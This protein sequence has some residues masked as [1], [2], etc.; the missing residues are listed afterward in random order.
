MHTQHAHTHTHTHT[1]VFSLRHKRG[2]LRVVPRWWYTDSTLVLTNQT[3]SMYELTASLALWQ[4]TDQE[5][6]IY[7]S[8]DLDREQ[9]GSWLDLYPWL[10]KDISRAQ[11]ILYLH[12]T[13]WFCVCLFVCLSVYLTIQPTVH[14][15]LHVHH[16]HGPR[17][18]GGGVNDGYLLD[19]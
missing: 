18:A 6:G 3:L 14:A 15:Q 9:L 5:W 10:I 19:C 4:T 12:C 13:L 2:L 11:L 16:Y 7:R 1:H 8:Q 17:N